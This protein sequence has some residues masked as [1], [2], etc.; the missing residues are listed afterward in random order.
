MNDAYPALY[1][2]KFNEDSSMHNVI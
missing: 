2:I 1:V